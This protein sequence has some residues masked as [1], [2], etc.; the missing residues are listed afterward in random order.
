MRSL[1]R[2]FQANRAIIV[3]GSR[4]TRLAREALTSAFPDLTIYDID[5]LAFLVTKHPA[6]TSTFE[7]ITREA[8]P[9]SEVVQPQP[10][11]IDIEADISKPSSAP[12]TPPAMTEETKGSRLCQEIHAI[13]TGRACA[14][15]FEEKVTEALRYIFDKDLTAWSS[16]KAS[17]TK[18]SFYDL[19]ARVASE[20]DFWNAIVSQF[21]SRYIVFEFK[22]YRAKIKQGQIYT[23]EKYLFGN[24]LRS[25]AIIISKN[26]ADKNALA[27]AR[28]ALRESGKLMVNSTSRTC[29]TCYIVKI[30]ATTI[31]LYWLKGLTTC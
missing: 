3:I 6:L 15:K 7:D 4:A 13:A 21:H 18:I 29:A 25:M 19:V 28:G 22:N 16:Q 8:L 12:D 30:G 20:H 9:F 17:D 5:T 2:A 26:G 1:R 14:R 10:V 11:K 23:T 31:T 27:A 24:A